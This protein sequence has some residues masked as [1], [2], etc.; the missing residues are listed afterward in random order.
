MALQESLEGSRQLNKDK[1]KTIVY[2][3]K[4]LLW[5]WVCT[6]AALGLGECT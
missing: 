4:V 1:K 2:K 6:C 3:K 5:L